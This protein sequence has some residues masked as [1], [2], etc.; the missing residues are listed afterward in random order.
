MELP[1]LLLGLVV[2]VSDGD[3][4]TLLTPEKQQVK[5]RLAEIDAPEKSQPFGQRS[6]QSLSA[7][8]YDKQAQLRIVDMD[9]YGRAVARVICDGTDA[10]ASQVK[11]GMAHVYPKYAK[12]PALYTLQDEA[13][14]AKRG[15]W[16]DPSP[17]PP[18]EF[19]K[20]QRSK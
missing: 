11:A 3:T 14:T 20:A 19:R 10:N 18:W 9:R 15:L 2:G 17:V 12:D 13:R 4:L 5:V 1:A 16:A 8:C 7:L 6:K